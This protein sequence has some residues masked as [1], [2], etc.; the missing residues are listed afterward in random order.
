MG[1]GKKQPRAL[2]HP[3]GQPEPIASM[4]FFLVCFNRI[5]EGCVC[6]F[7]SG[8][9]VPRGPPR[10]S[11]FVCEQ[12]ILPQPKPGREILEQVVNLR[13]R[14]IDTHLLAAGMQ[15]GRAGKGKLVV[16][17]LFLIKLA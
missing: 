12:K 17:F 4:V 9:C 5:R 6:F 10:Y 1:K 14:P 3:L 11:S 16:F 13:G 2:S 8:C 15:L 7:I